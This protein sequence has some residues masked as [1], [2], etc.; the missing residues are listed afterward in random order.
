MHA[1]S[2]GHGFD[3]RPIQHKNPFAKVLKAVFGDEQICNAET[4][5]SSFRS[6]QGSVA[7]PMLRV[8]RDHSSKLRFL[9]TTSARLGTIV[10]CAEIF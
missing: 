1:E 9:K 7:L 4:N 6:A 3:R 5:V 8:P 10:N 2:G